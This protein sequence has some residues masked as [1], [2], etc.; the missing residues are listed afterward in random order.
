MAVLIVFWL[1]ALGSFGLAAL[2]CLT[3]PQHFALATLLLFGAIVV[4]R[5]EAIV[6]RDKCADEFAKKVHRQ[7]SAHALDGISNDE[8][9]EAFRS[10]YWLVAL[11]ITPFMVVGVLMGLSLAAAV[12]HAEV[13]VDWV[14]HYWNQFLMFLSGTDAL[15]ARMA[16]YIAF[17][18]G[19]S[20]FAKLFGTWLYE[21][22]LFGPLRRKLRDRDA[23]R[24]HKFAN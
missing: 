21:F 17:A 7:M 15:T 24:Q 12:F 22:Y 14:V 13:H 20:W 8:L 6:N 1:S 2:I 9:L 11:A 3:M 16:A 4:T 23:A 19:S 5:I 10:R 18:A